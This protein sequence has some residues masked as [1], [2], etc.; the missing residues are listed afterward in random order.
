MSE[1]LQLLEKFLLE[2]NRDLF[3]SKLVPGSK[4]HKLF[5]EIDII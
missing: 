2:N 1:D 5:C 4:D 3:L